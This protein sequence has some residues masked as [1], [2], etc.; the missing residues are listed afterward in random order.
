[1]VI[2][3][4]K[5]PI[6]IISLKQDKSRRKKLLKLFSKKIVKNYF[7]A[8]DTRNLKRA[9][10]DSYCNLESIKKIYKRKLYPG[11]VGIALTH[12]KIY[13]HIVK[14]KIPN[15]LIFEDDIFVKDIKWKR[16]LGKILKEIK[17]LDK[18][19]SI[20]CNLGISDMVLR[21]RKI[22]IFKFLP[23]ILNKLWL[24][25]LKK[26]NLKLA[27]SYL[28]NQTAA[29]NIL[30]KNKKINCVA[31]DWRFFNQQKCFEYFLISKKLFFQN[32]KFTSR[33]QNYN[34]KK[35]IAKNSQF[36]L[37][38]LINESYLK[39]IIHFSYQWLNLKIILKKNI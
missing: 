27:H 21:K 35:K 8:V 32:K 13:R 24:L 25:D 5:L 37:F 22:F 31:D 34:E 38:Q 15:A 2:N 7:N 33:I 14:Y 16:E 26:N 1:M 3:D 28:I 29:K 10:L 4:T 30:S 12:K 19:E 17:N 11:E 18:N 36:I 9:K 39:P 20:L 6:F 23:K